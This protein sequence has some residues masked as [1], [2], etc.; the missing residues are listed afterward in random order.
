MNYKVE[1]KRRV[2]K[3]MRILKSRKSYSTATG[4]KNTIQYSDDLLFRVNP[5]KSSKTYTITRNTLEKAAEFF[6]CA[7]IV[8]KKDLEKFSN[9]SSSLFGILEEMFK[10]IARVTKTRLLKLA[11]RGIRVF[12]SALTHRSQKDIRLAAECKAPWILMSYAYLKQDKEEKWRVFISKYGYEG[13]VLL[14]SGA[15]TVLNRSNSGIANKNANK[16]D[17]NLEEYCKF[18]E[19]HK[20]VLYQYAQLD[21]INDPVSTFRNYEWMCRRGLNPMPIID[22]RSDLR[23]LDYM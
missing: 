22:I 12:L 6:Y 9:F 18:I 14:D 17:I 15:Y 7:R 1:A 3:Y 8:T 20:S 23:D 11:I 19:K 5:K 13:R 21:V 4:C 2:S 16:F 10:D